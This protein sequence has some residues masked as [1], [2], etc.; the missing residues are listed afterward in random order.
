MFVWL[1]DG[2]W[3]GMHGIRLYELQSTKSCIQIWASCPELL[4]SAKGSRHL[5]V[6]FL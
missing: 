3:T 6:G 5:Q 2:V 4:P 1:S